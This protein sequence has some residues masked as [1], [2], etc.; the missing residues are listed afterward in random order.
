M[1]IIKRTS[2]IAAAVT[3]RNGQPAAPT[4]DTPE[5]QKP[6]NIIT[7]TGA[8]PPPIYVDASATEQESYYMEHRWYTQWNWYDTKASQAKKEYQRLQIMIG[9]GSVTVPVLVSLA[10]IAVDTTGRNALTLITVFI[11]LLVAAAAAIENVKNYG[12]AW[13]TYRSAAEDLKREKS[14]YDVRSGPYR[15]SKRPFLLFV[16]RCEDIMAKQNGSWAAPKEEQQSSGTAQNTA[17]DE[18][19]GA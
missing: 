6:R 2:E 15:K 9:I 8:W 3:G 7:P 16:E 17:K 14:L 4:E 10:P 18:D 11:S 5:P 19:D 1:D 12:E 13:R